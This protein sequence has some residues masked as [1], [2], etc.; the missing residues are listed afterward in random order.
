M[1]DYVNRTRHYR[2]LDPGEVVFRRQPGP[3]RL[4]K[5]LFPEPSTGPYVVK[6]MPTD[7]SVVLATPEG[8]PVD[9]GRKVPL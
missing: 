1:Q 2:S 3:A 5:R 6:W 7:T 4:P 9:E 8:E